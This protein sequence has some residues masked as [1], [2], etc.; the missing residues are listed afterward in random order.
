MFSSFFYKRL[1]EGDS[2]EGIASRVSSRTR[3][4]YTNV[5]NWTKNVDIFAKRFIVVPVNESLHWSVAIICNPGAILKKTPQPVDEDCHI[6]GEDE[7][8]LQP[9]ILIMDSLNAHN[10]A[11]VS[12]YSA[13]VVLTRLLIVIPY[14]L[15]TTCAITYAASGNRKRKGIPLVCQLQ[16]LPMKMKLRRKGKKTT[17]VR[18]MCSRKPLFLWSGLVHLLGPSQLF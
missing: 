16:S 13:E 10:K 9:C 2:D 8:F 18:L 1:L 5:E 4:T 3:T 12:V 15:L 14:R 6:S 17:M 11:R 7:A